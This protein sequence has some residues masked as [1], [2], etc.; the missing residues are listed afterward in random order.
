MHPFFYSFTILYR[1]LKIK[2]QYVYYILIS[3]TIN[4]II[5][6]VIIEFYMNFM[7]VWLQSVFF[8][9]LVFSLNLP[10]V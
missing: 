10:K 9:Y 1:Q 6:L 3:H 5:I 7:I 4:L 2:K 8:K